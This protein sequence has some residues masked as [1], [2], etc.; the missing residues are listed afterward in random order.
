MK[1]IINKMIKACL[2]FFIPKPLRVLVKR[3]LV[4]LLSESFVQH[5]GL[6]TYLPACQNL[7]SE[8]I[9]LVGEGHVKEQI[10]VYA[11]LLTT[12]L[13]RFASQ[14]QISQ[15]SIIDKLV[16]LINAKV[17][18][19]KA[20]TGPIRQIP[21]RRVL[22]VCGLFP[23]IYHGGGLRIYDLITEMSKR[24]VIDL[25][26]IAH[27]RGD[28]E[29]LRLLRPHLGSVR[30]VNAEVFSPDDAIR[31]LRRRGV[32]PG[33]YDMIHFEYLPS[34]AF[35]PRLA[36][37]GQRTAFTLMECSGKRR[38]LDLLNHTPASLDDLGVM[39]YEFIE[40]SY[41]EKTAV[42]QVNLPIAVTPED[43]EFIQSLG[44]ERLEV[45]PCCVS[46]SQVLMPAA[47]VRERSVA[48]PIAAFIGSFD[49]YP[50]IEGVQWYLRHVHPL[51][52]RRVPRYRLKVIGRGD[53]STLRRE[54]PDDGSVEFVGEVPNIM[55]PLAQ[56]RICIAPLI[57][58][59]GI[60]VKIN[61]YVAAGRPVVTTSI[62]AEGLKYR[63]GQSILI[64]NDPEKFAD[65]I[66][67]LLA[68][69]RLYNRIKMRALLIMEQAYLWQSHIQRLE[70]YYS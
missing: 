15:E 26:S 20:P 57:S 32:K 2:L 44:T 50:N 27:D 49:H 29:T 55:D 48:E 36:L 1:N 34:V 52:V 22:Y 56:A 11:P 30:K 23:S 43:A 46:P 9:G 12:A 62:G 40:L 33:H 6:V 51:V 19:P 61:Q 13:M 60:R 10:K 41:Q 16:F 18:L 53:V 69:K 47:K 7:L 38:W 24:Y 35:I 45:I 37:F 70:K 21:T 3:K 42:Q 68:N 17:R 64:A 54:L 8:M 65:S 28:E 39:T 14:H 59:A 58:G 5:E 66:V 31:W 67:R 4:A 63:Q 25:Y